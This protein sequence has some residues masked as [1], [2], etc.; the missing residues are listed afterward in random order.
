MDKN[1]PPEGKQIQI[2]LDEKVGAGEYSNLAIVTHSAAEFI[3]DFTQ[4]MPGLPK[5][6]VRSRIIMSPLHAKAFAMALTD[7]LKKFEKRF[8]EIQ[9]AQEDWLRDFGFKMPSDKLP[10]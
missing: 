4:I 7:N 8:G 5:A 1:K 6:R 10:N 2:E 3:I 9:T